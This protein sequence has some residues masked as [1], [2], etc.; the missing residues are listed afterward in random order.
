MRNTINKQAIVVMNEPELIT[1]NSLL[2]STFS[3]LDATQN[4][5]LKL[6][7]KVNKRLKLKSALV[8][9]FSTERDDGNRPRKFIF[10]SGHTNIL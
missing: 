7:S 1:L 2:E 3:L 5:S 10:C 4:P 9:E 6:K 8:L